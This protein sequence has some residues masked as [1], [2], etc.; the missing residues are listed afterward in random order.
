MDVIQ[1]MESQ[2]NKQVVIILMRPTAQV[3]MHI[4]VCGLSPVAHT[5]RPA[6]SFAAKRECLSTG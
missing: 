3:E 6:R 4:Q 5:Y 1:L 2:N